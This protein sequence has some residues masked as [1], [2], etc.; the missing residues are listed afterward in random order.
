MYRVK[1]CP[2]LKAPMLVLYSAQ[3]LESQRPAG[4][5]FSIEGVHFLLT[6]EPH[7]R[8]WDF[9]G[10]SVVRNPPANAGDTGDTGLIPGLG[11]SPVG[12]FAFPV[13]LPGKSHG[14]RSLA[15]YSP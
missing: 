15:G 6:L 12:G 8:V 7:V 9:P 10:G 2:N 11:R 14:Q 13:V 3:Y 4:V 5:P 1:G